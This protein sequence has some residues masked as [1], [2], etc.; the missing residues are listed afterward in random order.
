VETATK[1]QHAFEGQR[2]MIRVDQRKNAYSK[3][4]ATRR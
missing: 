3:T 1:C 2:D 4:T